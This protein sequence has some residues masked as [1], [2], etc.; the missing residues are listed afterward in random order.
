M[1]VSDPGSVMSLPSS[2]LFVFSE[3][4][5]AGPVAPFTLTISTRRRS[6][7]DE[8]L[9]YENLLYCCATC[10]EAKGNRTIPDPCRVLLDGD[11]EVDEDGV[12]QAQGAQGAAVGAE[13]LSKPAGSGS[14]V[15][16]GSA[17]S[18]WRKNTIRSYT[19]G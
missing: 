9:T 13:D 17:S 11:V 5:G 12:L 16:P 2:V 6:F 4:S 8:R 7:P 1:P 3:S 19:S 15:E 14:F 10:N 18:S